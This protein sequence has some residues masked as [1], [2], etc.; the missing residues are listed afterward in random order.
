MTNAVGRLASA[1][2]LVGLGLAG[3][4]G[5][6]PVDSVRKEVDE[7]F[8]AFTPTTPGCAVGADVKGEPVVRAS[9]GMADL[10]HD[11]PFAVDTISSPGSV[12]KQFTAAAVLL[13]AREGKLSLDDP[14]RRYLPELP[15]SATTVTI[16][17]MLNH[18]AGLRD[19]GYLTAMAGIPRERYG[20]TLDTVLDILGRQRALDFTP[21]R[22]GRTATRATRSRRFSCRASAACRFLRSPNSASSI[23][24]A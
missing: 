2:A 21:A 19:W 18:T 6:Q 8:K 5:L 3:S 15:A 9:Y 17:Q 20:A 1:M 4:A 7:I 10:E 24:L 22:V 11:V 23:H 13:L 16:R 14:A 12:A